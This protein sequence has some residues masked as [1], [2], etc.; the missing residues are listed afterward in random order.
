M[1]P[2]WLATAHNALQLLDEAL[3]MADQLWL[4]ALGEKDRPLKLGPK[5]IRHPLLN[6]THGAKRRG[7]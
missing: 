5:E 4:K 6:G 1:K 2:C 7:P 3:S